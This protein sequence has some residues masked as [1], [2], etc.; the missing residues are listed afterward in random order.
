MFRGSFVALITP[1]LGNGSIDFAGLDQLL[2][3]HIAAGTEGLVILGT[4][5][6]AV[7]L[8]TEEKIHIVHHAVKR[9][10]GR[11]PVIAGTG[12]NATAETITFTQTLTDS[13]I[14]ACLVVTPY[15]NKP[16]QEGLYQHY[17]QLAQST[18]LP[19]LLYNVPSRTGCDM[20]PETVARLAQFE[21]IVGIK[22]ANAIHD[23]LSALM[24]V[25]PEHFCIMSGDDGTACD[26]M[27]RGA[28]GCISVTANVVPAAMRAL[29]DA[30]LSQDEQYAK[31]IDARLHAL[32]QALFLESNPIPV[33]HALMRL[34]FIHD[35]LRLPLTPL[36]PMHWPMLRDA[37]RRASV[38]I[39]EVVS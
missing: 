8:R 19:L 37:L 9:V 23:R 29:C 13:G 24:H 22:E 17:S 16:T 10:A 39:N 33:K 32:H 27:L 6:E 18:P 2:D 15:Y 5:G 12:S 1:M 14:D 7:T 35:R 20:L 21:T 4:T 11:L 34:G 31:T 38:D 36:N 26:W 25:C 30:A 3:M 28:S